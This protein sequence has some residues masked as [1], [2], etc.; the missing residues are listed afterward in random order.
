MRGW[1]SRILYSPMSARR[2]ANLGGQWD[3]DGINSVS[4]GQLS[5]G[6]PPL[7]ISYRTAVCE[8]LLTPTLLNPAVILRSLFF[9]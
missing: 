7:N 9:S 3:I 5:I 1:D 2:T 8:V 4:L 6:S